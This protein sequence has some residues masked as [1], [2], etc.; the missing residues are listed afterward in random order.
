MYTT[1]R[2]AH[3][4]AESE[5]VSQQKAEPFESSFGVRSKQ[6]MNTEVNREIAPTEA[7]STILTVAQADA[8]QRLDVYLAKKLSWLSRTQIQRLIEQGH[9]AT[10]G[11]PRGPKCCDKVIA[12]DKISVTIPP[13]Q[14][15][16]PQ[17]QD[18]PLN[19]L[20]E[21]EDLL[22]VNK[23]VGMPV[24]PGAGNPDGTLVNA[25]L[26]RQNTLSSIG[27]VQRPG[28]VHRL[29]K[30]TTG[31]IL[32]AKND[33]AHRRLSEAL[34]ARK[35]HRV[36]W[37]LVLRQPPANT[38][39]ICA[40]VARHPANRIKMAVVRQGGKEAVTHW[41]VLERFHGFAL[42]ECRLE[43]GRT[44][45]IRVHMAS[46]GHP[47]LGDNLYGGEAARALQLIPPREHELANTIRAAHRQMLHARELTFTHPRT[48]VPLRFEAQLPDDFQQ[49]LTTLQ[50]YSR[51]ATS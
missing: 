31:L 40:P 11:S 12:G 16:E 1:Q 47:V 13:P 24:H 4:L 43:T 49:I 2:K 3:S 26:A 36:Y 37:A 6:R 41:K 7:T 8:G 27:G 29:D 23:P 21:D 32:V 20:Y 14:P 50:R 51:K 10:A 15:A 22:V 48:R 17:P 28:I 46:I 30:D 19:V 39:V 45:Q 38:G 35:I 5:I 42:I 18:I 9:V 33:F 34:A 44:H 25:L